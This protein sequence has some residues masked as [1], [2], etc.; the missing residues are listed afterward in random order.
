MRLT[1][2]E[3][4]GFKSFG[5][6]TIL[7]FQPGITAIVGPNGCGKSNIADAIL[8]CLGEQSPKTLRGDRMED[9]LF[10]GSAQRAPTGLA[11]V[12]LTLSGV[13]RGELDGPAGEYTEITITRRLY[14]SGES[15]Y[16]IN[17]VPCRLKDVR[18]LLI[19]TGA[20]AKGHTVLEQGKVDAIINASPLER[21]ALVEETA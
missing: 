3:I 1:R 10:N 13:R 9:V 18:D 12:A 2:L 19:E 4:T 7:S 21:R 6:R 14:R 11:E 8:W 17:R 20:G 15:E 5:E 16:L